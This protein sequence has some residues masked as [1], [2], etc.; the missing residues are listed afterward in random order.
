MERVNSGQHP[1]WQAAFLLLVYFSFLVF[2]GISCPE[3][4]VGGVAEG[5]GGERAGNGERILLVQAHGRA[6]V[7]AHVGVAQQPSGL[8]LDALGI[9]GVQLLWGHFQVGL[10]LWTGRH[11]GDVETVLPSITVSHAVK[12]EPGGICAAVL[13]EGHVVTGFDA[14]HSEQLHPLAGKTA[15]PPRTFL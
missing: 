5:L 13:D 14:Q 1:C 7:H 10:H 11:L 12:E 3:G 8:A 4:G 2:L 9:Q 15:L 6:L